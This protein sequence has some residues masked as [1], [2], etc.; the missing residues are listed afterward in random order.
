MSSYFRILRLHQE[1]FIADLVLDEA[2]ELGSALTLVLSSYDERL[3][4]REKLK[5]IFIASAAPKG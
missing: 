1:G 3:A 2:L 4:V 5:R